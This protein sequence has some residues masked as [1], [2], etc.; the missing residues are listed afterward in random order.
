MVKFVILFHTPDHH[1]RFEDSYNR[2]LA[3]V[4]QM[5]LIQR[6][7]VNSV[8]GSPLGDTR[9][10]RALEVY[11]EDYAEMDQSLKSPEG[12]QAGGW[13]MERFAAGTFEFY[14]AE[15]FEEAGGQTP[16]EV[17]P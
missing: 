2:F 1:D 5:P 13:L 11:Y 17:T 6:R 3:L 12:Q 8:L 14:F 7:Q 9:L 15:V 4:E 10:Y 16:T